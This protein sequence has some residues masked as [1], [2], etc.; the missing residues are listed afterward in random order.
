M[1]NL[2]NAEREAVYKEIMKMISD[3]E[4]QHGVVKS[5]MKN[6]MTTELEEQMAIF[7]LS[8]EKFAYTTKKI[9]HYLNI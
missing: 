2:T 6:L 8:V 1:N 9:H 3:I 5:L 7:D 4:K